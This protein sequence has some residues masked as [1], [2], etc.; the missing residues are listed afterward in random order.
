MNDECHISHIWQMIINN[1][2]FHSCWIKT[3]H[4]GLASWEA[5]V[6][7]SADSEPF[8]HKKRQHHGNWRIGIFT[9]Q[10][11]KTPRVRASYQ[12]WKLWRP[13]SETSPTVPPFFAASLLFGSRTQKQR[14][15][16]SST[17]WITQGSYPNTNQ[18][19]YRF[20]RFPEKRQ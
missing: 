14:S 19:I 7:F 17:Y 6:L 13:C 9:F 10:L 20:V 12:C 15:L 3:I 5:Y 8:E 16:R 4:L 11:K 2:I 1:Y 18:Y